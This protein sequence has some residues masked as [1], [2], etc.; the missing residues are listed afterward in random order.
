MFTY[1][2][3]VII[4]LMTMSPLCSTFHNII[5]KNYIEKS[6]T[7]FVQS[8]EL[9][10]DS[11][12]ELYQLANKL[13]NFKEFAVLKGYKGDTLPLA[14]YSN[15]HLSQ[16]IY[17]KNT[18]TITIPNEVFFVLKNS[19]VVF[20]KNRCFCSLEEFL[21]YDLIFQDYSIKEIKDILFDDNLN[22]KIIPASSI[23]LNNSASQDYFIILFRRTYDSAVVGAVFSVSDFCALFNIQDL[24]ENSFMYITDSSGQ[25]V[26]SYRYDTALFNKDIINC[27]NNDTSF[28]LL[29]QNLQLIKSK[30]VIGIPNSYFD[31]LLSPIR[32][33][34]IR[35]LCM[36]LLIGMAISVLLSIY[37]FLPVR[38]LAA[39]LKEQGFLKGKRIRNEYSY[40]NE[41][42][43]KSSEEISKLKIDVSNLE[44]TLC[45][46]LFIRVLCGMINSDD[47]QALALRL[48]PQLA[49]TYRIVIVKADI[50]D[51]PNA[52]YLSYVFYNTL[53]KMTNNSFFQVL[54][55]RSRIAIL[56][57]ENKKSKDQIIEILELLITSMKNYDITVVAG[58]SE[59]V[60][61][62]E[63]IHTA[64]CHA[65][66][67]LNNLNDSPIAIYDLNRGIESC[68]YT[69]WKDI[70]NLYDLIMS[71]EAEGIMD[72]IEYITEYVNK[73][74][75]DSRDLVPQIFYLTRSV[76]ENAITESKLNEK[77][78]DLPLYRANDTIE[79]LLK[80]LY[81]LAL[82]VIEKKKD[83]ISSTGKQLYA[84][85][86]AYIDENY[87]DPSLYAENIAQKFNVSRNTVYNAV[88][89]KTGYSLNEYIEKLRMQ[90]AKSLLIDNSD[91]TI[92]DIARSCGYY[93]TNTFYKVF[94][95]HH[96]MSPSSYRNNQL[97]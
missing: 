26:M 47:E 85:I 7:T 95:K 2:L 59:A 6:N 34:I 10:N 11:F 37:S 68:T 5:K 88:K 58:M 9:L 79:V 19:G 25:V 44:N 63:K 67:S 13:E 70:H 65:Q 43:K 50:S 87:T 12:N 45:I 84:E 38:K 23:I 94:K 20:N 36:S 93:T 53:L 80:E 57:P 77:E 27:Q 72:V 31:S 8:I 52:D 73:N 21:S 48:I 62:I 90:K 1:L 39:F 61:G 32:D 29:H 75:V 81:N 24:P 97:I 54:M 86:I 46:N 4:M 60:S 89:I 40:I 51:L 30:I 74:I 3:V 28:S 82:S 76:I 92:A 35:Y 15:I 91:M 41:F 56:L 22:T 83:H 78:F 16:K 17:T 66:F 18:N 71:C 14:Y 42:I 64:Y 96:R 49:G 55:D 33:I 69:L